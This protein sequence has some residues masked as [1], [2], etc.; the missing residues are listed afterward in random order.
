MMKILLITRKEYK[1]SIAK[2]F[3]ERKGKY[4]GYIYR[5]ETRLEN[6]VVPNNKKVTQIICATE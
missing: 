5:K 4:G 2:R 1:K 6:R 3:Q